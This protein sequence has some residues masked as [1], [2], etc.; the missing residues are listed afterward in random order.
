M[1]LQSENFS[2]VRAADFLTNE[3]GCAT[4]KRTLE[5]LACSGGGPTY[6][7]FGR[8]VIYRKSD[9]IAWA[10]SRMSTPRR[11]TSEGHQNLRLVTA[12]PV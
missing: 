12:E 5:K 4:S 11:H 8:R 9:L 6:R 7:L 1:E 2:R 10:E 3:Y